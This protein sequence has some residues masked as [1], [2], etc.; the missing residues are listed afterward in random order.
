MV[1]IART[2]MMTMMIMVLNVLLLPLPTHTFSANFSI[3]SDFPWIEIL[4]LKWILQHRNF[5]HI[6]RTW[7]ISS[8][9]RTISGPC[10]ADYINTA[11]IIMYWQF[12]ISFFFKW[13]SLFFWKHFFRH[14]RT[15]NRFETQE[16]SGVSSM[17][18][19]MSSSRWS[20]K[21]SRYQFLCQYSS[22]VKVIFKV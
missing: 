13:K 19:S 3:D 18:D 1:K 8:K 4:E 16:S 14:L 21:Y 17:D 6:W 15:H 7:K 22:I 5:L 2:M 12:H 10:L 20:F 11:D 9:E